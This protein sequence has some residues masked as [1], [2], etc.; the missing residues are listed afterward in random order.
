MQCKCNDNPPVYIKLTFTVHKSGVNCEIKYVMSVL[1]FKKHCL[2]KYRKTSV[3]VVLVFCSLSLYASFTFS[4]TELTELS[5]EKIRN[6]ANC[7]AL[8]MW[9]LISVVCSLTRSEITSVAWNIVLLFLFRVK[10]HPPNNV[11]C[12][13]FLHTFRVISS[14]STQTAEHFPA[15]IIWIC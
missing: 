14:H 6:K 7:R 13:P 3:F 8:C 5:F 11:I 4:G 10:F 9:C 12:Q 15:S 2:L 1:C